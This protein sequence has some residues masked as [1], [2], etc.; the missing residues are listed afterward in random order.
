MLDVLIIGGGVSGLYAAYRLQAQGLKVLVLEANSRLGGRLWTIHTPEGHPIDLG[1]QWVGPQHTRTL[2]WIQKEKIPL[3]PTY[4]EGDNLLIKANKRYRYKGTIPRLS[5]AAL[6][7]L[8][9]GL[10]RLKRLVQQVRLEAPWEVPNPSWDA[11]TLRAWMQAN[12]RTAEARE[13]FAVGLATVLGCE[14]E[15]VSLWHTLVYI[16]SASGLEPLI[17]TEGGAQ[18]LKFSEGAGKLI[19]SLAQKTTWQMET[20]VHTLRWQGSCVEV[21]TNRGTFTARAALLALPPAAMSSLRFEPPLPP[22]YQQLPQRMPMGSV[23]KVVAIY[24]RPFWREEGLSGHTLSLTGALR[25]TFDTSPPDGAYGQITGFAV[26]RLARMLLYESPEHR[27]AYYAE[28]LRQLFGR[29]ARWVYQK[30]W[31][32]EPLIG[33]CYA[34]YFGPGGWSLFGRALRQPLPPLYWCGTER[35]VAWMGYIEGALGAAEAAVAQLTAS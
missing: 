11:L 29:P 4:T 23:T 7:D 10:A 8:G 5:W 19:E 20:R 27:Q 26:G 6:V 3:H 9:W 25:I 34:G 32:E 18:A 30:T 15:E 2:T 21:E 13:T 14:P 31:A 22:P 12:L 16:R 17:E 35:A 1:G 33:G 28:A 24:D